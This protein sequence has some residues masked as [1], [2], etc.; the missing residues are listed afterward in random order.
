MMSEK[1]MKK[2][3]FFSS[4]LLLSLVSSLPA[5]AQNT[6]Y[7]IARAERVYLAE[8][9]D[10]DPCLTDKYGNKV[11]LEEDRNG[12]TYFEDEDGKRVYLEEDDDGDLYYL[13]G[14]GDKV[15]IVEERERRFRNRDR[16]IYLEDD[17]NER[18]IFI[19]TR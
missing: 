18:D 19:E 6:N 10:G 12:N 3:L 7:I 4:I 16:D 14:D 5:I 2:L 11:D 13:D 9:E 8:D 1:M 15:S 17:E